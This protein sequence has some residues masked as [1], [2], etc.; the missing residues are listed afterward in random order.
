MTKLSREDESHVTNEGDLEQNDRN[1]H[2][3]DLQPAGFRSPPRCEAPNIAVTASRFMT[4]NQIVLPGLL[5][6]ALCGC[7]LPP[8][9]HSRVSAALEQRSGKSVGDAPAGKFILPPGVS[10]SSGLTEESAVTIALWNNA[11]FQE[12]LADLG[13]SRADLVQAGMLPNP[14]LSMLVPWGAKGLEL[15]AKYPLETLWLRPKRVAN[16]EASYEQT[17]QRLTQAGLDLIRDVKLAFADLTLAQERERAAGQTVTLAE[18]ISKLSKARLDAGDASE[19]EEGVARVDALQ[20]GELLARAR[21]DERIASERLRALLGMGQQPFPQTVVPPA[22]V[23]VGSD[24]TGFVTNALAAR[25]DLRAAEIAVESSGKRIGLARLE[26][27][28][29]AAGVNAKDVNKEFLAGPTVDLAVPVV[30]Q[31][32]GGIALAKANFEKAAR[33]YYAVRDRIVLEVREAHTRAAQAQ[34]SFD[35]WQQRIVP[36]LEEAVRQSQKAYEVGD[37]SLLLTL[38]S[39]RRL[40]D[41]RAKAATARAELH[42]AAAELERSLGGRLPQPSAEKLNP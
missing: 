10:L 6:A 17:V 13:I 7:Q 5:A 34:E 4:M 2:R 11:A 41:A 37:A 32:Q 16:A 31:N 23:R 14:T 38:E 18:N 22:T 15:T 36:P 39:S 20:A 12:T 35:N 28:T 9:D 40:E 29:L 3:P 24:M 33:H 1:R 8:K 42:R 21:H 19:L 30:N 25:P 26:A 27:F